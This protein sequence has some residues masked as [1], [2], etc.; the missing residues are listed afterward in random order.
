MAPEHMRQE[1]QI[2]AAWHASPPNQRDGVEQDDQVRVISVA[3]AG[4]PSRPI[5]VTCGEKQ[6][7]TTLEASHL[8]TFATFSRTNVAPCA[9]TGPTEGGIV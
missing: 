1:Q 4:G 2:R 6:V 9:D 3:E 5:V 7:L 8:H